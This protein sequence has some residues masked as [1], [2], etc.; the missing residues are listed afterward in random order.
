MDPNVDSSWPTDSGDFAVWGLCRT[1]CECG[2]TCWAAIFRHWFDIH[3]TCS[4]FVRPHSGSFWALWELRGEIFLTSLGHLAAAFPFPFPHNSVVE[5]V[6]YMDCVCCHSYTF[7]N[8]PV[9]HRFSW[10]HWAILCLVGLQLADGANQGPDCL[11]SAD[12]C[13][14]PGRDPSADNSA[15]M[16][17]LLPVFCSAVSLFVTWVLRTWSDEVDYA[18]FF[19]SNAV[20]L[21]PGRSTCFQSCCMWD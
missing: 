9:G 7:T 1:V 12:E 17:W 5:K 20:W 19:P 15:P 16:S 2:T 4:Q 8:R 11:D 14:W 21:P 13:L 10:P 6:I 3:A 18:S